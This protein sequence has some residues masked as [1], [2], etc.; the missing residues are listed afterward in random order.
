MW[1][2]LVN[3]IAWAIGFLHIELLT[4]HCWP[5][6]WLR[7]SEWIEDHLSLKRKNR[8]EFEKRETQIGL[9]EWC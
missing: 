4:A 5:I 8:R 3:V 2:C 6:E 7:Q 1:L 9:D